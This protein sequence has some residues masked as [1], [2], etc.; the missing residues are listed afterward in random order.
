ME[1][2]YKCLVVDD[3]KPAHKVIRS[4]ISHCKELEYCDSAYNGNEA[5]NFI[6]KQEY[7]I[8]FLDIN[9]PL[10]SG[11][12]LME[13]MPQR[14]ITIVTTAYSDFAL[15]S[16]QHD[17]VDYLLKPISLS[18][19][20]KAVAKAKLFC[21]ARNSKNTIKSN[22]QLKVNGEMMDVLLDD[23]VCIESVGNYLKIY[24]QS[25]VIP[26]V[27]YG[28]LIEIK[29]N[30]DENFIQV[31]RSHIVN[32]SHMHGNTKHNLTLTDD[33]IVPIG[34]KYQILIDNA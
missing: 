27:V 31:H 32:R 15:K 20:M 4:H 19:F 9:M 28:S 25:G 18:L 22:I 7:D 13:T 1:A 26:V 17:A 34:R 30:L 10:V 3:E 14:P 11:I 16:Y 2:K 29:E 8:I 33:R 23:I 6:R 24:L 5:M 21:E 12:E